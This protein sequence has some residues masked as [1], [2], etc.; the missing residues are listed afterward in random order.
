MIGF[1]NMTSH[2]PNGSC[3]PHENAPLSIVRPCATDQRRADTAF[4]GSSQG[5]GHLGHL[6]IHGEL[7][8]GF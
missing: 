7:E 1:A 4:K 6:E 5:L 2:P 8:V 3:G